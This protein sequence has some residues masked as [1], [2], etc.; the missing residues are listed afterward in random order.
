MGIDTEVTTWAAPGRLNLIG[1]H[2][3][4]NDG[5]VL[6]FA[7]DRWAT[8]RIRPLGGPQRWSVTSGWASERIPITLPDLEPGRITGWAAYVAGVIWALMDAGYAVPAADLVIDSAVAP[9]SGLSSSAAIECAVLSALC[10]VGSLDLPMEERPRLAQRAENVYV[11]VPC[12]IMDQSASIL[13]REGHALLLDCRS[14]ATEQIPC[15]PMADGLA[16]LVIDTRAPHRHVSNEYRRRREACEEAARQLGVVALRD[17]ADVRRGHRPPERSAAQAPGAPCRD[18]ERPG[19]RRRGLPTAQA[20]PGYRTTA[21]CV[22]RVDAGRFR[23]HRGRSRPGRRG[24]ARAR[25]LRCP[26]DRR[27]LWR[28]RAGPRPSR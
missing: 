17:V 9:G 5:F 3:D 6:P 8:V 25:S 18:R 20:D 12:G 27:R 15:D 14:L 1:E 24:C 28:L 11:G 4:Y 7:L 2:T 10:G 13:C 23:D 21:H 26:D 16:V 19:A 22:A